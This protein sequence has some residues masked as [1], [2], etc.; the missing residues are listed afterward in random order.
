MYQ[1][2]WDEITVGESSKVKHGF[3]IWSNGRKYAII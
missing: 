3:E 2:V 1:W